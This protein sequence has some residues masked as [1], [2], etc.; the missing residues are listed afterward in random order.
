[1]PETTRPDEVLRLPRGALTTLP[2]HIRHREIVLGEDTVNSCNPAIA[3]LDGDGLSEI[4]V[5]VTIGEHDVVKAFRGNGE[6]LWERP[7]PF[8]HAVYGDS[9]RPPGGISARTQSTSSRSRNGI[10]FT[11]ASPGCRTTFHWLDC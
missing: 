5:P 4:V 2:P 6:T 9:A 3:D 1:M 10:Y 8:Y 7:V 11:P